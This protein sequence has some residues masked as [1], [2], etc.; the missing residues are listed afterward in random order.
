MD[1]P[2][3]HAWRFRFIDF[4]GLLVI[5]VILFGLL[6]P[7]IQ[8]PIR[9]GSRIHCINNLKQ[10]GLATHNYASAYHSA[11]PALTS[12]MA[13]PKYGNYNGSIFLTLL[14]FMESE[15]LFNNGTML[16]P[17]CTWYAPIPPNTVFPL[18]CNPPALDTMP[19]SSRA[20]KFYQCESD[21][22][23]SN[24]YSTNQASA[25]ITR[26]PYY[27]PWAGG[28]YSANYQVFGTE[29][30]FG[31]AD[32]G[33][34]CGPKY[35]IGNIPDGSSNTIFY[36][37]QFAACGTTAGNLW[38][39]PGIGNYSGTQYS[40]VP[41]GQAP[42][43]ADNSIVNVPGSTNSNLWAPV[44]ANGN[45]TYGFTAGGVKGSIFEFNSQKSAPALLVEPYTPGAYWDAPPQ[46]GIVAE[47][48][49]K[50]RL[51]ALHGKTVVVGLGDGS[52][53]GLSTAVTQTTWHSA[54]VPDDG[55]PFGSDW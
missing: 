46:A 39:Y 29:N 35:D 28:N 27:F 24:G 41:G 49:D 22:T 10:I 55:R 45:S 44:F 30:S 16:L 14:P 20:Q 11:L 1:H 32:S 53:R 43:G 13:K 26:A 21:F 31:A 15:L 6:A 40:A 38:A 25:N 42:T 9:D 12:D 48:C 19:V 37:E 23:I 36:G 18:A 2:Q 3:E 4:I 54:I 8:G 52:V 51:Q 33:N 7:A 5:L 50:S 17:S 47:H 34:S